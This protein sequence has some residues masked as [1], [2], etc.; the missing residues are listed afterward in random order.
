[1]VQLL[2][3]YKP[4]G[5]DLLFLVLFRESC[6]VN[7]RISDRSHLCLYLV[8]TKYAIPGNNSLMNFHQM[9]VNSQLSFPS[10]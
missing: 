2:K 6:F 7:L 4:I 5:L 3:C 9:V 8:R 10:I 1:M